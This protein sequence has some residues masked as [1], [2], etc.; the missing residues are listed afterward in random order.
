MILF[1]D[2]DRY[3]HRWED[4]YRAESDDEHIIEVELKDKFDIGGLWWP[5]DME[6]TDD[7]IDDMG[8]KDAN[9]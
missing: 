1:N 3:R 8:F 9:V 6:F 2:H 7:F 5:L 4:C